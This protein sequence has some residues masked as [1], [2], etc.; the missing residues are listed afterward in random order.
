MSEEAIRQFCEFTMQDRRTAIYCLAR[1]HGNLNLAISYYFDNQD[2][3]VIPPDFMNPNS[4]NSNQTSTTNQSSN[5]GPTNRPTRQNL[6]T[7]APPPANPGQPTARIMRTTTIYQKEEPTIFIPF[8]LPNTER[9]TPFED[10]KIK[11]KR[12]QTNQINEL[13]DFPNRKTEKCIVYKNGIFFQ[14]HFYPVTESNCQ[15]AIEQIQSNQIPTALDEN[16]NISDLNIDIE[17]NRDYYHE[18]K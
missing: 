7:A 2:R 3:I 9:P 12:E 14:S 4:S 5:A 16:L 8:G 17:L 13:L 1:H 15:M 10:Q 6:Q 18:S 11:Y